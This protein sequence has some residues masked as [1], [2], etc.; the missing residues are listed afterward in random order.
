LILIP[1]LGTGLRPINR[2][3]DNED[4]TLEDHLE[5]CNE[6]REEGTSVHRARYGP[7]AGSLLPIE[8]EGAIEQV[9]DTEYLII[10]GRKRSAEDSEPQQEGVWEAIE[11]L[12]GACLDPSFLIDVETD[13]LLMANDSALDFYGYSKEEIEGMSY[14]ELFAE[15]RAAD[16]ILKYG[17]DVAPDP[18]RKRWNSDGNYIQTVTKSGHKVPTEVTAKEVSLEGREYYLYTLRSVE[19]QAKYV[20]AF[21]KLD[22]LGSA[23]MNK[24]S[25]NTIAKTAV[26]TIEDMS[27]FIGGG[28][29]FYDE[30]EG[31]LESGAYSKRMGEAI[32]PL[33][34][35]EPGNS[36]LWPSY[37]SMESRVI[38]NDLI[39]PCGPPHSE[40]V[41]SMGSHGVLL[42]CVDDD[43]E[44]DE[45][46]ITL[47]E[48]ICSIIESGLDRA[49][50][51]LKLREQEREVSIQEQQLENVYELNDQVRSLN[52]ALVQA[53]SKD[54]IRRAVANELIELGGF[55]GILIG[56]L[57]TST[58]G[59][60]LE[61]IN[62]PDSFLDQLQLS[63]DLSDSPPTLKA[64]QTQNVVGISNIASKAQEERWAKIALEH[65]YKSAISI[66]LVYGDISYGVLT[67]YSYHSE[68]FD[69]RTGPV[70]EEL[71][72]LIAYAFHAVV[73]RAALGSDSGVDLSI[74]L[75]EG[76]F[77]QG[78][79][80]TLDETVTVQNVTPIDDGD[81]HLLHC[82]VGDSSHEDI[83]EASED[84]SGI[85]NPQAIGDPDAGIFQL[86]IPDSCSITKIV[87]LGVS[88]NSAELMPDQTEVVV[89][90]PAKR[91]SKEFVKQ[92]KASLQGVEL[93]V[94]QGDTNPRNIPWTRMLRGTL[95]EKQEQAL[96]TAYYVGYFDSPAKMNGTELAESLGLAQGTVS[97]RIRAAQRNLYETLWDGG[98]QMQT[99]SSLA[100]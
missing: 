91:D 78:F 69:G 89:T 37:T 67:I 8:A 58:D 16:S 26:D 42:A 9:N 57:N 79:A 23:I 66:P 68:A 43:V 35:F 24:D 93:Q 36:E 10:S 76:N 84:I 61:S 90:L 17:E 45:V 3:S 46:I 65:E 39:V 82:Y 99:S 49:D 4:F 97:Y 60:V 13:E 77:L 55:D 81:Y 40:I 15:N 52:K 22:K 73:S 34:S 96:R 51:I 92:L 47:T 95:T 27:V 75:S 64:A 62:I 1:K 100:D 32:E 53:E 63:G 74:T 28:V 5:F 87:D 72:S 20:E 50:S 21:D 88:F 30:S 71:G 98:A 48:T 94:S 80:D 2:Y 41:T 25:P 85:E 11:S 70:L 33:S 12:L 31:V 7:P 54:A 14:G 6:A 19:S 18:V 29:Y 83:V 56:G 59:G 44:I 86:K 38:E